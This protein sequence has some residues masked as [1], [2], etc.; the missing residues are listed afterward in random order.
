ME[1]QVQRP[2]DEDDFKTGRQDD[3]RLADG[4]ET[5]AV[6]QGL[7]PANADYDI[8]IVE[9]VYRFVLGYAASC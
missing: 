9:R 4:G 5:A 7:G 1:Q 3:N 2:S 6:V 8:E